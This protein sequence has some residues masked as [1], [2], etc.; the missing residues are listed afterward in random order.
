VIRFVL[1]VAAA[2]LA[3]C[4][5][6]EGA[7][8]IA[9]TKDSQVD[10]R[11]LAEDV[12][13]EECLHALLMGLVPLGLDVPDVRGATEKALRKVDGANALA[14][15]TVSRTVF[16]AVIYNLICVEVSGDAVEVE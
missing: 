4:A 11:V 2:C 10:Y 12:A 1:L 9:M 3:G 6:E 8:S 14:R 16:I 13:G 7:L 5:T 15:V